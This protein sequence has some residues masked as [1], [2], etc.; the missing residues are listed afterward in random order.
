MKIQTEEFKT[1]A[2]QALDNQALQEALSRACGHIGRMR[3]KAFQEFPEGEAL[4]TQAHQI[5]AEVMD[6]LDAYLDQLETSAQALGVKVHRSPD[7]EDARQYILELVRSRGITMAVKGK[8]MTT[9]EIGLNQELENA[10]VQVWETDLG[11]FIV[12]LAGEPPSHIIAPAIHKSQEEIA[13][14]FSKKLG[15]PLFDTPEKLTQ[16]AR[17]FLREKYFQAR[18]GD[19]RG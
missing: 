7:A 3:A 13:E 6:H 11:E 5:K 19:Q 17:E 18:H 15:V 2:E 8:S 16:A 10:Q 12:Q 14:L 9:E 1:Q 4:R